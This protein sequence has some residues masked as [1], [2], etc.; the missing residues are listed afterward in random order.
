MARFIPNVFNFWVVVFV[1]IGSIAC[2][3]G[4]AIMGAIIGQ[5]S[6]YVSLN[7]APPGTPGY[8]TT[9]ALIGAFNGLSSAGAVL[10]A[11]FSAWSAD[12]FSRKHSMQLGSAIM[13]IGAGL[14]AGS[15]NT[16]MFLIARFIAG[17]G[18]GMLFS[19]IPMY[20]SEISTPETRGFMVSIHGVMIGVGYSLSSWINFGVYFITASGSTSSFPWRFPMAFQAAPVVILLAGS[21][22]LPYSPRW[23]MRKG[24]FEEAH[25]VLKRL[26]ASNDEASIER[27]AKEFHQIRRQVEQDQESQDGI[28]WYEL[29]RT[30]P[31]RKRTIIAMILMWGAQLTGTLVLANYGV[32]LFIS[33]GLKGYMPLLLLGIW[34]TVGFLGNIIT[35]LF[36]DRFGRRK[37]LL[38]GI[39]G[40]LVSLICECALQARYLG[41]DNIAGLNAAVFFIYLF[42][43]F[44]GCCIDATQFVYLTE[45]FPNHIRSQGSAFGIVNSALASLVMLMVA[46]IALEKITWRFFLVLIVPTA[47]YLLVIFLY[48]PE[49][50]KK[51]LED[52]NE[53]FG[54]KVAVHYT[55]ATRAEE[56]EY[57]KAADHEM[58]SNINSTPKDDGVVHHV[59]RS[60]GY[61]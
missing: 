22:M 20:Q 29:L 60:S 17:F 59:E 48:F 18:L 9:S 43:A 44:F 10:G 3:Y 23:L 46:P 2:S 5:P 14:C 32:L 19:I 21:F 1:A 56:E 30:A 34:V 26:H 27:V 7:L 15:I 33:L 54:E 4:L 51:S 16:T 12:R 40:I 6:F 37:F 57:R 45:I 28:V 31:N 52:I 50:S 49:T 42:I 11:I 58:D 61:V 38:V 36:L 35:A 25:I 13:S 53:A 41:T 55:H 47:C 39:S 8:E 24:R